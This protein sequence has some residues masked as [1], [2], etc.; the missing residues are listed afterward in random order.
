M[1]SLELFLRPKSLAVVGASTLG[2]KAGGRRWLSSVNASFAGPLY[3]INKTAVEMNGHRVYR[4][5]KEIAD[6]VDLVAILVPSNDV[7]DCIRDCAA[8]KVGAVV[9]ISAGFGEADERGKAAERE[10]REILG[11]AGVRMI[12]PNSAGLFSAR[13]RIN[14]LGRPLPEGP[15]GIVT[16]SGNM[17]GTFAQ[18]ARAKGLGFASLIAIGNAANVSIAEAIDLLQDDPEVKSI[19]VYCEGFSVG[20]GRQ[21]FERTRARKH[22]KP[23]VVL[24]P[25]LTEAGRRAALSH[26]GAIAG[27]DAVIEAAFRQC[28]IVRALESEEA[29][30]AAA[31]LAC[32]WPLAGRNIAIVSDG[33]GHATIVADCTARYGLDVPELGAETRRKL[34]AVLPAR[35]STKNPVDFAGFAESD[36]ELGGGGGASLP[37]GSRHSR[38]H[39]RRT[40]RRL[41]QNDERP[42]DAS[43]G[44][45][46]GMSVGATDCELSGRLQEADHRAF[47][48][49]RG[50][51]I[52]SRAHS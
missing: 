7:M 3:P 51:T 12:G 36:P 10:M 43:Q 50:G 25:G 42:S 9:V 15:I 2:N 28:G 33:G 5:L 23:V 38:R 45:G 29:W 11:A 44:V 17:A 18:Q 40:L 41:F 32:C 24:K 13:G 14:L 30:D 6:P 31:A 49:C 22:A 21:L 37:C 20:E 1:G 34:E 39:L 46:T 26:T 8:K 16:Q 52:D 27:E 48:I 19:L 35:S 47:R 4:S